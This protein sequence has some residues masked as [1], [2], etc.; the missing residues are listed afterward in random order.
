MKTYCDFFNENNNFKIFKRLTLQKKPDMLK[1]GV[2]G[3]GH[4]GKFT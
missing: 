2:L 4:L 3:A 1:I